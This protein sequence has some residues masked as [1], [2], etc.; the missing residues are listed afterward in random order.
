MRRARV[1]SQAWKRA[2]RDA[3]DELLDRS[4]LG[5]RTKRVVELLSDEISRQAPELTE[6]AV[7]LAEETLT[8]AGIKIKTP[9]KKE[10]L[11]ESGYLL[12][13]SHNQVVAL[14]D[15][16]VAAE[17]A[18]PGAPKF[19]KGE[20]PRRANQQ[21]SIDVALFGRMV[22]DVPDL[23]VDAAAQ[24]AH[25]LTVHAV[26]TEFDYFTAVDDEKRGD[27]E[28]DPARA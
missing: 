28:E 9:R 10:A 15:L 12:F 27:K 7:P 25:A 17:R 1:S 22:A 13:L 19:V 4:E 23:N 5:V 8:A 20:A 16:A 3:F 6:R 24:V 2:T 26:D 18:D 14:A 11:K 21:H